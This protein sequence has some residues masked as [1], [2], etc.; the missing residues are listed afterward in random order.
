MI[1]IA[2]HYLNQCY[3]LCGYLLNHFGVGYCF[4]DVL[5]GAKPRTIGIT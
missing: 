1:A 3:N 5:L 2:P 4:F